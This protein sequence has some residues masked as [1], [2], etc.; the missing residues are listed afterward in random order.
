MRHDNF[1]DRLI[2][3]MTW[4]C[5]QSSALSPKLLAYNGLDR[6]AIT[7]YPNAECR[8]IQRLTLGTDLLVVASCFGIA[9]DAVRAAGIQGDGGAHDECINAKHGERTAAFQAGRS[10]ANETMPCMWRAHMGRRSQVYSLR[11]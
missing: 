5:G 1:C 8:S 10:G 7:A 3:Q 2:S 4:G 9:E 6:L 11:H